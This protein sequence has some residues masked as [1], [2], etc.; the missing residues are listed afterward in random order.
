MV[1]GIYLG[2]P[3]TNALR[4]NDVISHLIQDSGE[5]KRRGKVCAFETFVKGSHRGSAKTNLTGIHGNIGSIPGL[6][7]WVEGIWCCCELWCRSQ[8]RL[9]SRVAGTVV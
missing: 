7:Q 9:G 1:A 6:P 8:T 3:K 4:Q 5:D 2:N